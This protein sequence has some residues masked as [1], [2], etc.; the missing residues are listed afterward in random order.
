MA[1][2]NG[3]GQQPASV[4]VKILG[5][6]CPRC[7]DLE[8]NVHDAICEMGVE[9]KVEHVSNFWATVSYGVLEVPGLWIN[10]YVRSQGCVPNKDAIKAYIE[11]ALRG[12]PGAEVVCETCG[13][14]R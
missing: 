12:E 5:E 9:A 3:D 7:P 2:R 14:R 4:E 1:A 13:V 8:T 6:G 11:A 10:G